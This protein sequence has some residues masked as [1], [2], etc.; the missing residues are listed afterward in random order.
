M[1]SAGAGRGPGTRAL[2]SEM[3]ALRGPRAPPS[4]RLIASSSARRTSTLT[5]SWRYSALANASD[6][7]RVPSAAR[8]A[9]AA[10]RPRRRPAPPRRRRPGSGGRPMF[11]RATAASGPVRG[12][13]G[14]A[15]ERPVLRAAVELHVAPPAAGRLRDPDLGRGPRSAAG[16]ART[17]LGRS[18]PPRPCASRRSG[19]GRRTRRRARAARSGMSRG[20]VR[21]RDRSADRARRG[22]PA[23]HR[24]C[25]RC[26]ATIGQSSLQRLAGRDVVVPGE[27]ADRDGDRPPP[28]VRQVLDPGDVDEHRGAREPQPHRAAGASGRRRG[29]SRP[30]RP[31]SSWIASSTD[32]A[33]WY[34]NG[35]GI[36][37][38]LRSAVLG[39]S[40]D[41]FG[42]RRL[43]DVR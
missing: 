36:M 5:S 32:S 10:R 17:G 29:S 18:R 7:G 2:A 26:T 4:Y 8:S 40:P 43:L 24:S 33:R 15:D 19:P 28:D 42:R 23:G 34:S 37:P 12:E 1:R 27:R 6:G 22:G 35:A 31:S 21:V 9:A 13:R 14:D 16:R 11:V 38:H 41:A 3:T 30:G 20:R 25:S 39:R